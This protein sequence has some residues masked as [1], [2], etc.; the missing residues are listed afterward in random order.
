MHLGHVD[1]R[2]EEGEKAPAVGTPSANIHHEYKCKL[3]G[4]RAGKD[5]WYIQYGDSLFFILP[6]RANSRQ[7]SSC[8]SIRL[9]Q[10]GLT[11]D[12]GKVIAAKGQDKPMRHS[13]TQLVKLR[14][15]SD[16]MAQIKFSLWNNKLF[17]CP[18]ATWPTEVTLSVE[19][20]VMQLS[21]PLELTCLAWWVSSAFVFLPHIIV[22]VVFM[23]RVWVVCGDWVSVIAA[24][25]ESFVAAE[26]VAGDLCLW[27]LMDSSRASDV[28]GRAVQL[29]TFNCLTIPLGSF[30]M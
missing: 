3:R 23:L 7:R 21:L 26:V 11:A 27:A 4:Q 19:E 5:N 2:W 8:N 9:G 6:F 22:S 25:E 1:L 17:R 15:C 28:A 16:W 20:E 12:H 18:H 14:P 10:R 24:G 13:V 30:Q 29:I